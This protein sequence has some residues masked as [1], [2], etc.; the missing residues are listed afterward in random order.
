MEPVDIVLAVNRVPW[1]EWIVIKGSCGYSFLSSPLL[2]LC[3]LS[4][5]FAPSTVCVCTCIYAEAE[6]GALSFIFSFHLFIWILRVWF[7]WVFAVHTQRVEMESAPGS[8]WI[9]NKNA[10]ASF[11]QKERKYCYLFPFRAVRG[12]PGI[13]NREPTSHSNKIMICLFCMRR[14]NRGQRMCQQLFRMRFG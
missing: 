11:E 5:F 13:A 8:S 4:S 14:A 9:S 1:I 6:R 10:F 3:L 2:H 7:R 12:P